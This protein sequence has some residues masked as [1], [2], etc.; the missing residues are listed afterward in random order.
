MAP[1]SFSHKINAMPPVRFNSSVLCNVIRTLELRPR[2]AF[3]R[4][5]GSQ[6]VQCSYKAATGYLYPL[7]R[8]FM[9][10]HKPPM[11]IRFDEVSGKYAWIEPSSYCTFAYHFCSEFIWFKIK[12]F[13]DIGSQLCSQ[14]W[15]YKIIWFWNWHQSWNKLHIFWNGEVSVEGL[16]NSSVY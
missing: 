5:S 10:V 12:I 16:Q 13:L 15:K 6:C 8:G 9:F 3:S 7:E 4:M 14:L 1:A 2:N 11:H